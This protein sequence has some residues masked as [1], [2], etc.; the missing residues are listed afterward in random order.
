MQIYNSLI[1]G[2]GYAS[3]GYAK[4]CGNTLI[5]DEHQICDTGFYFPLRSFKYVPYEAKTEDGKVLQKVF[6]ELSL[7]LSEEQ[8]TNG[9]ECAISKYILKSSQE[10]LL[11]SRVINVKMHSDGIFDITLSTNEGIIHRFAKKVLRSKSISDKKR[12]TVI[13]KTQEIED[14]RARLLD[15]FC[16]ADIE[17]AFYKDRFAI[18]IDASGFDENSIKPWIYDKWKSIA[19][20]A[21]IICIAPILYGDSAPES[22]L[23]DLNY[24]NPIEAF[25]SGYFYAKEVQK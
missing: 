24:K 20:S 11:K 6:D 8:N 16:G 13:F 25:E 5:C 7:F 14:D 21:K 9:F 19:T 12:V 22:P 15:A 3:L 18:H 17:P 23:C 1:I 4:A 10:V 2:C